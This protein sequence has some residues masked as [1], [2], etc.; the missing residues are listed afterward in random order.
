M[1]YTII[2]DGNTDEIT[3]TKY[4]YDFPFYYRREL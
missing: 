4:K 1:A 2:L 3:I